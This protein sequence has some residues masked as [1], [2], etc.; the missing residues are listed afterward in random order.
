MSSTVTR[1]L[2]FTP[3]S[4]TTA[5]AAAAAAVALVEVACCTTQVG[6]EVW[7]AGWW[8]TLSSTAQ[9]RYKLEV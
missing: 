9:L 4:A 6:I 8:E 2:I 1:M 5:A 7:G 3:T